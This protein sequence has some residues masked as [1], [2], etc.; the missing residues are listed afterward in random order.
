MKLTYGSRSIELLTAYFDQSCV[1]YASFCGGIFMGALLIIYNSESDYNFTM[2]TNVILIPMINNH[3]EL[4]KKPK[5]IN[6][7]YNQETIDLRKAI[8]SNPKGR[9][10]ISKDKK[11]Y[12][13]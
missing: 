6:S 7:I 13:K 12:Q 4:T 1:L 9:I 2:L 3:N 8:R 11:L 5:E 10:N